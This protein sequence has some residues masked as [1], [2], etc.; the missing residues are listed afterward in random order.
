MKAKLIHVTDQDYE[1]PSI[2]PVGK[3][4]DLIRGGG[5]IQLDPDNQTHLD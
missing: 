1:S 2:T 3:A 4:E 5:E